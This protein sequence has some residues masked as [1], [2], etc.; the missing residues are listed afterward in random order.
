MALV[1][2]CAKRA[3]KI[4]SEAI[5]MSLSLTR[6]E[7]D[8]AV[9]KLTRMMGKYVSKQAQPIPDVLDNRPQYTAKEIAQ[10]I[11]EYPEFQDVVNSATIAFGRFLSGQDIRTL[12]VC[13]EKLMYSAEIMEHL[14]EHC[15]DLNNKK[16]KGQKKLTMSFV[17]E[18][19]HYWAQRE[20]FTTEEAEEYIR[21]DTER[22]LLPSKI[23]YEMGIKRQLADIEKEQIS[24]WLNAGFGKAEIL[25]A[26]NRMILK[27][28]DFSWAYMDAILKCWKDHGLK[29]IDEIME[30][31]PMKKNSKR[32]TAGA[33]EV[34]PHPFANLS[35]AEKERL[36]AKI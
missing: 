4:D 8:D 13:F 28:G 14:L 7:V 11:D 9:E 33:G 2:L 1:Y 34:K 30:K 26:Y 15:K 31:D 36:L 6:A 29:T 20:I 22:N 3:G 23:A 24:S 21:Y 25:E 27:K 16:N 17:E 5:A 32:R 35:E 12:F 10:R 18:E 19:A